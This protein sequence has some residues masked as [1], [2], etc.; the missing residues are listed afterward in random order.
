MKKIN[1]KTIII[2]FLYLVLLFFL[3]TSSVFL[4][5]NKKDLYS[6]EN[7]SNIRQFHLSGKSV[8]LLKENGFVVTPA[9]YKEISDVYLECKDANQPT[10][11][12]TDAVL[13]T[14]HIFF[15]YLLRILEVEKL[16]DSAVKLTD[17]MLE[18][19]IRQYNEASN[20]EV[21]EAA[22]LNIAFFAVAKR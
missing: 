17:R 2:C 22:K 21:K 8:E 3:L 12:T 13:H 7:I 15:D 9:Y 19:S 14:G 16:Y 6:L 18:L 5:E 10:F 11:I 4:A 1:F 20:E